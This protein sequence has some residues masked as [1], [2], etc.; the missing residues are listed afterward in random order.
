M[1]VRRTLSP[2]EIEKQE[3]SMPVPTNLLKFG[4]TIPQMSA[5]PI[6]ALML[7]AKGVTADLWRTAT[8]ATH[9]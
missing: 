4:V 3:M 6:A 1:S 2:T 5:I 9:R 7:L 8:V